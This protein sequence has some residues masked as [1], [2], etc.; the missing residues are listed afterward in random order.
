MVIIRQL[1]DNKNKDKKVRKRR[2]NHLPLADYIYKH[3]PIKKGLVI[4]N[5][6]RP[7]T[8]VDKITDKI[9]LGNYQ[10]AKNKDFFN[11]KNIKAVL[12]CTKDLPNHFAHIKDIEYMRI[13][14]DDSLKEKDFEL[15]FKFMP[16][17]AEFI[18]K[19]VNIQKN[20]ILIHCYAGRQRSACAVVTFLM[21]KYG[22]NPHDS[23]RIVLK[24]RPEAFHY[25]QSLNF[26][27]AIERYY[28]DVIKKKR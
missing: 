9:Y 27:Q 1:M 18:N 12:N 24:K 3:S 25:G 17:I 7:L 26:D 5:E 2:Q 11:E 19:H 8:K 15:M 21:D 16:A 20:N 4:K 23:C 14:V 22:L 13:P 28:K 6:D 10:T